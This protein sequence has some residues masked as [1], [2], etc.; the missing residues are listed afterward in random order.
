MEEYFK[1]FAFWWLKNPYFKKNDIYG[2]GIVDDEAECSI[3]GFLGNIPV[4]YI[5]RGHII[6][7]ASPTTW[8]VDE[9]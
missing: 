2:W 7:T 3:K 1:K 8:C 4:D 5:Y 9:Q 6:T